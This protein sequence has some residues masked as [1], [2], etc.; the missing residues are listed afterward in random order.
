MPLKNGHLTSQERR[1]ADA[2]AAT[3]DKTY[4]ATKAGYKHPHVVGHIVAAKPAMQAE[5]AKRELA[6]LFEEGLPAAVN[7]L[8]ECVRDAKAPHNA[9]NMAAKI[10]LDRTLGQQDAFKGRDPHEM[11]PDE[12]ARAIEEF[13]RIASERARPIVEHEPAPVDGVFG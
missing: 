8:V 5:I 6:R 11:T 12:I 7:H 13:K 9:K 10:I 2:M 3:G 1:F 4:A